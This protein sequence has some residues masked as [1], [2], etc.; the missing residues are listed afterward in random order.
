MANKKFSEFVLKTDTSDVSHI[1]GY[2]GAE[3]VQITP[4][5]FVTTGGTGVFLPLAGGLM[6]GNTT[7]NDNVKSIYG[8]SGDGLEI[9][10]DGSDSYISDTGTGHLYVKTNGDGIYFRSETNEEIAHFNRNAGVKLFYD[11][12]S[13]FETTSTGISVTG[14]GLFTSSSQAQGIFQG[15]SSAGT[16]S[17]S[18]A[19]R[20]GGNNN[21][22]GRIDYSAD[23]NTQFMFENTFASGIYKFSIAGSEKMRLDASGN[24][25]LGTASPSE[26]LE[27]AG[28]VLVGSGTIDNPQ[29]WGKVLQVQNSGSNGASLSVKD[30]NN[31]W[32]LATYNNG[33]NISDG[34]D[35]RLTIDNA[36]NVGVGTSTPSE[37]LEIAGGAAAILIDSTTNE[38][39]LKYDNSTTT[40]SIKLSNN[41]L[42]F[43]LGGTEKM[44]IDSSGLVKINP[45]TASNTSYDALVLT[46]G[47]NSTTGSG[48][49]MYLSG[50]ANDPLSRGAIIEGLITDNSNGHALKFYTSAASSAPTERMRITSD[51]NLTLGTSTAFSRFT[52]SNG[53]SART[54][55]T[56]SDGNTCSLMLFA[57]NSADAVIGV[58]TQNLV[59]KT[60]STAG[61]DN[62]TERLKITASG[63]IQNAS[64]SNT[65]TSALKISNNAG[66]G[67]FTYGITI[68]DDSTQTGFILFAAQDGSSVGSITRSNSSTSFNTSSDYRLKE[69]LQ[70]FKGLD[71]VS[72]I[73]VYDYKWKADDS[74]SYGVMAHE[75]E[76]VLPQAVSGEKDAEEMQSVDY[77]KIVPLLVKS[78][79]ELSAKLEALECQ[80]EKK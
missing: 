21:F 50:T 77:S 48:A 24:L 14:T 33:F 11:N 1:V 27:V 61:Q 76:E 71:L 29:G 73:P 6:V 25:G 38:A 80:C 64:I 79:Q 8:T 31:E 19:I 55:I 69:D 70:D 5:N 45:G 15:W 65:T 57:G 39:S 23:G 2:N 26:K 40:S 13:K 9:Y 54:G 46:G 63:T 58:D 41:D 7:H 59:F 10:H 52:V 62:G 35:E 75:L 34:V 12:S 66:L 51:G 47:V 4:A 43:E 32:N 78:I 56:L 18:G 16:N 44:R 28:N 67:N 3:N 17:L 68:E 22:Q 42:K 49:K 36:G 60:G 53:N 74:R 37:K 20:L 30:S 72:K